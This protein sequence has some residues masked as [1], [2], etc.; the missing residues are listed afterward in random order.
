MDEHL[1]LS[2]A[3]ASNRLPEFIAQEE[4]R[5]VG[6]IERAVLDA[7]LTA[8]VK[9]SPSAAMDAKPNPRRPKFD[10]NDYHR[11]YMREYMRKRRAAA[12]PDT[13]TAEPSSDA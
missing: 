11:N 5:G 12:K 10:R 8:S 2:E 3:V 6:P 13:A 4:A 1:S 9:S 7:V